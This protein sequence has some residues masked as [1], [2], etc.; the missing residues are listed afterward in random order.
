MKITAELISK[1]YQHAKQTHSNKTYRGRVEDTGMEASSAK[2][3]I[4]AFDAMLQGKEYQRSINQTATEH[5]LK[6]ITVDYGREGLRKALEAL[7][8]HLKYYKVAQKSDGEGLQKIYNMY[9]DKLGI[10]HYA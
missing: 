8:L 1:I 3:Y 6:N 5:Y 9:A 4:A 2:D 10:P 7:S